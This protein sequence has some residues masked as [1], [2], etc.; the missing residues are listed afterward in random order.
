MPRSRPRAHGFTLVEVM[1]VVAII[2]ILA[3]IALPSYTQYVVQA[4]RTEAQAVLMEL[5]QLQERWRVN[6]A[7]YA[8]EIGND[9]KFTRTLEY[10]NLSITKATAIAYTLQAEAKGS[11][12]TA[13]A[14]CKTLT[15]NENGDKGPKDANGNES[16][17]WKK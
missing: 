3:S 12:A 1:I 14:A 15:L 4:R 13:D 6:N 17:C 11:Q 7:V 9:L 5:A 8:D 2:G 16:I 10:Y